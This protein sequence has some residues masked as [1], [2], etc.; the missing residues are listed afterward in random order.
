M[1]INEKDLKTEIWPPETN[2]GGQHVGTRDGIKVEHLPSG[3]VAIVNI[4][5]SQ[6]KNRQIACDM[7]L[8]AITHPMFR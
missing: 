6:F 7:I 2:P 4:G 8:S 3:I 5:R 1:E